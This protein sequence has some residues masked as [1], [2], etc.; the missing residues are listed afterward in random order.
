MQTLHRAASSCWRTCDS[1]CLVKDSAAVESVETFKFFGLVTNV[2]P[3]AWLN[4]TFVLLSSDV[5]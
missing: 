3:V 1:M 5:T 2:V 4:L